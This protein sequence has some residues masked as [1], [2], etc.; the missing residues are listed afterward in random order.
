MSTST[1]PTVVCNAPATG[2]GFKLK[3]L[4][5]HSSNSGVGAIQNTGKLT[6]E[7]VILHKWT[8]TSTATVLNDTGGNTTL[9]GNCK[10]VNN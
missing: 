2:H 10:V 4:H 7:D 5:I 6:L 1:N 9:I 8:G 3:G